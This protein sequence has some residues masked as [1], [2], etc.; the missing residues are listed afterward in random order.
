MDTKNLII[1][2]GPAGLAI[3]G[4]LTKLNQPYIIIEKSDK[5]GVA[6]HNHY[7]RLHLHTAK[8]FSALPHIPL[9]DH[10]PQYVPKRQVVEYFEDYAK[11]MNINPRFNEAVTSV[12][13]AN[14]HWLTTTDKGNTYTSEN[15]IVATGF[16]RV[17]N[18]PA[19]QGMEHFKG[20]I[21]HSKY[22][23]NGKPYEGKN[24][25]VIGMGNSG[26]EIAICLHEHGAKPYLSVRG[27]VNIVP[28]EAI[29]GRP[30]QQTAVMLSKLPVW[31]GDAIG[32]LV[33][34]LTI[35]DL[36]KYGLE[37]PKMAPSKQLR[38]YAKTPVIDVG[39]VDLIKKGK[40]M[41]KPDIKQF[42]ETSIAFVDGTEVPFDAVINATGFHSKVDEFLEDTT[43]ALNPHGHPKSPVIAERKGLYF[44]GYAAYSSGIIWS[45]Y[46]NSEVIAEHIVANS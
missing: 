23:K 19:W 11:Q 3:A 14:G 33:R 38:L 12:K 5:V 7:D 29:K 31:L 9:P 1:G 27:P 28:K 18:Q 24:V 2:A 35:G 6:W 10:Y 32:K 4:R 41:V 30:T 44:L 20:D 37:M 39:T 36:S 17:P 34:Q 42:N 15:V 45:I 25:L 26:A 13:E 8:K 46:N 16:N 22:Y 43:H 40:I 21:I